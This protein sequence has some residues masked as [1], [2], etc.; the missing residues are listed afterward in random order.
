ML[1][2]FVNN[3][4]IIGPILRGFSMNN[5]SMNDS[6]V[7][8]KH[9][10]KQRKP[11]LKTALGATLLM[12]LSGIN[13]VAQEVPQVSQEYYKIRNV[14]VQEATAKYAGQFRL[15]MTVGADCGGSVK[16]MIV[17]EVAAAGVAIDS[18]VNLGK[19]VWKLVADGK[20]VVKAAEV[21]ANA[22]PVG[23]TCWTEME[24]WQQPVSKVYEIE[25]ENF[26]GNKV[27][28]YAVRVSF[29][30]GGQYNGLGRYLSQANVTAAG[31]DVMWGY[32]LN[33]NAA[34]NAIYNMGTKESPVAGMQIQ[35][36]WTVSNPLMD[37]TGSKMFAINGNGQL[38]ELQ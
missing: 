26:W 31:V 14:R 20:A 25:Y 8:T 21:S 6:S 3:D 34:V 27:V 29:V 33:A 1:A 17:D 38:A 10:S 15:P 32:N 30:P 4:R 23:V 35:V 7:S 5:M 22:M 28:S 19:K 12:V 36:N 18:I 24:A 9:V 13:S 11:F 37:S 16:P 2:N